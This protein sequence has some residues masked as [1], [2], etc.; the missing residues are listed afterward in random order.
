MGEYI[1]DFYSSHA[2]LIIEV[3]GYFH[4]AEE[5]IYYERERTKYLNDLGYKVLR[6]TNANVDEDFDDVCRVI[7]LEI[8]RRTK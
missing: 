2:K 4:Y 8:E 7:D 1:V 6:F 3:D 5:R